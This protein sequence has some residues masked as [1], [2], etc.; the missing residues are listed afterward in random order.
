MVPILDELMAKGKIP[1]T[2]LV[3]VSQNPEPTR[4]SECVDAVGGAKA[5]TYISEDA[6]E[7]IKQTFRAEAGRADWSL[8]GYS[9]GGYCAVTLALRHPDRFSAAV[10][11]DGYF[12]PAV[13]ASTG[14]LFKNDVAAKRAYTAT[15]IIHEKREAPLRFCLVTGDADHKSRQA[16]T[17]FSTLVHPPDTVQVIQVSGGHNWNSWT[18]ALPTA[19][20]WLA[21]R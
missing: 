13:D 9:T 16:A 21:K 8:M 7:V 17:Q 20:D 12:S 18:G 4:D 1:P 11:L 6:T 2:I 14:D 15:E 10:S 5:D 19:L 3:S